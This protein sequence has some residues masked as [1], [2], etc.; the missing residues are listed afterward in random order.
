[1]DAMPQSDDSLAG[2]LAFAA[3]VLVVLGGLLALAAWLLQIVWNH[4][5]PA[6]GGPPLPYGI[7]LALVGLLMVLTWGKR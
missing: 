6:W 1:M 2:C 5:A 7:A 3:L 4:L